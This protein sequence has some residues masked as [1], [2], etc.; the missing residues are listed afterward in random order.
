V[1]DTH[2]N[3][4]EHA[5]V[6]N[7][8]DPRAMRMAHGLKNLDI[9]QLGTVLGH[10]AKLHA[11][12]RRDQHAV[13]P[14][15]RRGEPHARRA[16]AMLNLSTTP[17]AG[18]QAQVLEERPAGAARHLH[19]TCAHAAGGRRRTSTWAQLFEEFQREGGK[20]G[21]R[22]MFR[23]SSERAEAL[24][25]ELAKR[26]KGTFTTKT[27]GPPSGDWLS[28]YNDA[29]ENAVRLAAYKVGIATG[30]SKQRAASL[31]KNLTVNFNRK[32][33]ATTQAAALYAFFNASVQGTARTLET[34]AGPKGKQIIAGGV[35]LGVLQ[36]MALA[37]AGFDDDEPPEFV[38]EKNLIIPIGGKKY[39][40]IP[41]PQGF[42]VLPNI[43]RIATEPT[44]WCRSRP[45]RTS[46]ASPSTART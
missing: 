42:L 6:F 40:T 14:G 45:T 4:V 43:G 27:V 30:L 21:Y 18:K 12:L 17:L 19:R 3:V 28:D 41:M 32:G 15:L 24:E 13:Q 44:R 31:A 20:T 33:Q 1:P 7:E 9:D 23:T 29:M 2:G 25:A 16:G 22:D 36:A 37:A 34:L 11:L 46:R 5:V 35:L 39:V 26:V 10:V 8:H 38:R